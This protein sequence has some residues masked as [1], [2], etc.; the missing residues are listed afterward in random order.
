MITPQSPGR[1]SQIS[2]SVMKALFIGHGHKIPAG[3]C[4]ETCGFLLGSLLLSFSSRN[5]THTVHIMR[6]FKM[7]LST[8][9]GCSFLPSVTLKL[10]LGGVEVCQ[11]QVVPKT[12]PVETRQTLKIG[13][14][15]R[16]VFVYNKNRIIIS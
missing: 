12:S 3:H 14:G 16:D 15:I 2:P 4:G 6:H 13:I 9:Q 8:G 7:L 1:N 10:N 11:I 5:I